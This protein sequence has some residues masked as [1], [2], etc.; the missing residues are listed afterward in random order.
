MPTF[1]EM[2][3]EVYPNV[4]MEGLIAG[5]AEREIEYTLYVRLDDIEE[6][7][8]R[9]VKSEKHE[10]W[11][12]PTGKPDCK[13]KE[14]IRLIDGIRPTQAVKTREDGKVGVEEVEDD[15]TMDMFIAKRRMA[16]DGYFKTRYFIPAT[17]RGLIWEIDV[18][19]TNGG[20]LSPWVKVDLEVKSLNDPIPMFPLATNKVIYADDELQFTDRQIVKRLWDEEWQRIDTKKY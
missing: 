15:I 4:S 17:I 16:V 20:D 13:S 18:F 5:V 19:Y 12:I 11:S 1:G 14:R 2:L 9:A 10:Q 7:K 3:Q 8:K 6:L